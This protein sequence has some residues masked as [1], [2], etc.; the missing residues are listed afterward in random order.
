[1]LKKTL[2]LLILSIVFVSS[3]SAQKRSVENIPNFD[4]QRWHWGYYLGV[5]SY[6]FKLVPNNKGMT[7]DGRLGINTNSSLGFSVGLIGDV[8]LNDYFNF[9]FEP[10]LDISKRELIYD[11]E[12][13][14]S[15]YTNGYPP[16]SGFNDS[17]RKINSTYVNLPFLL[18][19]GGKRRHNI[20]P[21]L[22][23]GMNIGIDLASNEKSSSDNTSGEEGSRMT[24][25]NYSWQAGAGIDWYLPYFKFTTE[26]RGSFGLNNELIKD[27]S[28]AG[29]SVT[30]WTDP[31]DE[32]QTR[33]VFFVIKFE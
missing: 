20:R 8:R 3:I 22:I 19:F 18:K 26:I 2:L 27:G 4:A 15:Y 14:D 9:R 33:A 29:A 12:I 11:R 1:M 24:T 30:P 21:Y 25:F 32:L 10:G 28:P 5:N 23:G 17:I 13:L 31:I 7:K 16:K 6:S